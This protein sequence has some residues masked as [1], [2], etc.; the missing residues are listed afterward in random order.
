MRQPAAAVNV[1]RPKPD[2]AMLERAA[3][4]REAI[5]RGADPVLVLSFVVW[6]T[7]AVDEAA[8]SAG[9]RKQGDRVTRAT[10]RSSTRVR[11]PAASVGRGRPEK[12]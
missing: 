8:R 6:P 4:G 11:L 7:A 12:H 2:R 5:D 10:P 1:D 9:S 3:A